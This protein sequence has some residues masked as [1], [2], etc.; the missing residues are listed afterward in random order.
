[1]TKSSKGRVERRKGYLHRILADDFVSQMP[2]GKVTLVSVAHDDDCPML[3][4]GDECTCV[5]DI[6][7]KVWGEGD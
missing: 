6:S 5:P 2:R 4:G 7:T 3:N 1:M